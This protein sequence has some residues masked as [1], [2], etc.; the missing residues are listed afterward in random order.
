MIDLGQ[1]IAT[2]DRCVCVRSCT[3]PGSII[4]EARI[5]I[6]RAL[7]NLQ[8]LYKSF[9]DRNSSRFPSNCR[10][11]W[12][13]CRVGC[14]L[15]YLP[16][17]LCIKIRTDIGR[18]KLWDYVLLVLS[19]SSRW[20]WQRSYIAEQHFCTDLRLYNI[21]FYFVSAPLILTTMSLYFN[22]NFFTPAGLIAH[23]SGSSWGPRD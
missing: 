16:A 4:C 18:R 1:N 11:G 3:E 6:A 2:L 12:R 5:W 14:R 10:A 21:I 23:R 9:R 8:A 7:L 13:S 17:I 22:K 19:A 20:L 15:A